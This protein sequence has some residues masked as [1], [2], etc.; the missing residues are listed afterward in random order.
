MNEEKQ[1]ECSE[2]ES[3]K[4]GFENRKRSFPEAI[5]VVIKVIRMGMNELPVMSEELEENV[6]EGKE[7][8]DHIENSVSSPNPTLVVENENDEEPNN[9]ESLTPDEIQNEEQKK[10]LEEEKMKEKRSSLKTD[11]LNLIEQQ[12]M[13]ELEAGL[14]AEV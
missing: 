4:E 8:V 3:E 1:D 7:D 6:D 12:A 11:L 5:D 10:L 9:K 14:E 2:D 13:G